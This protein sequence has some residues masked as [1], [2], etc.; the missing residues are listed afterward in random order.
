MFGRPRVAVTA[1]F[2]TDAGA[3]WRVR[4]AEAGGDG[5]RCASR[6]RCRTAAALR[7]AGVEADGGDATGSS[8]RLL[9]DELR[10]TDAAGAPC[11]CRWRGRGG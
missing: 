2:T 5:S 4:L 6:F 1:L 8:Y 3:T 9:L 11:R 7:L 10:L